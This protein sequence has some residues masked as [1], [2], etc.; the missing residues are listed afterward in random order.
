MP[1]NL[2]LLMN[3]LE[4][5]PIQDLGSVIMQRLQDP[6]WEVR[7]SVLELVHVMASIAVFSKEFFF[8]E[9][10][11]RCADSTVHSLPLLL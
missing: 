3:N 5:S 6:N 7:D 10:F 2:A 11:K 4:G 9:L 8:Y 1:P